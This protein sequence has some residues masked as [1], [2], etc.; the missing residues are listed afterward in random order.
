MPIMLQRS[1]NSDSVCRPEVDRTRVVATIRR[2]F[3]ELSVLMAQ[4][5]QC[6]VERERTRRKLETAARALVRASETIDP[7]L[8]RR[9]L[10]EALDSAKDGL[11]A[12]DGTHPPAAK[13]WE[14]ETAAD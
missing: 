14:F 10:A 11:A 8:A 5:H 4:L 12:S 3:A 2:G 7:D 6:L 1:D 9:L 13:A